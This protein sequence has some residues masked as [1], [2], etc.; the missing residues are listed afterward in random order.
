MIVVLAD[1]LS[2]AAEMGGM[3]FRHGLSAEVLTMT[4][5]SQMPTDLT[6]EVVVIDTDSRSCSPDEAMRRVSQVAELCR[7]LP[8]EWIFKKVDS[9]L[10]GHVVVELGA[11]LHVLGRQRALLIPANPAL[12][13]T[14]DRG[15]YFVDG[16]LLHET[17]FSNDPEYPALTSHVAELL[18]GRARLGSAR[19]WP[20]SVVACDEPLPECGIIVG[21]TT[22]TADLAAWAQAIPAD[23]ITSGAADFFGALLEESGQATIEH[24]ERNADSH[25]SGNKL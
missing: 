2:G 10:R 19:Q 15:R 8:V 9:V 24:A 4:A 11:L 22:S 5:S 1:D 20:I 23:V 16:R 3:A 18:T 25:A 17:D 6:A 21:E 14:I 7:A 13:R 12:G